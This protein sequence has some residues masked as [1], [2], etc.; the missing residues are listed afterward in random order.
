MKKEK[1][2]LEIAIELPLGGDCVSELEDSGF[3]PIMVWPAHRCPGF[4]DCPGARKSRIPY[5]TA[6]TCPDC[7]GTPE[8]A[9]P[10]GSCDRCRDYKLVPLEEAFACDVCEFWQIDRC[11]LRKCVASRE[12]RPRVCEHQALIG[13]K[14]L[15]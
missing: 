15:M 2:E 9:W 7:K 4:E 14:R 13:K 12:D 11:E 5:H 6:I 10:G 1:L 3:C 8:K